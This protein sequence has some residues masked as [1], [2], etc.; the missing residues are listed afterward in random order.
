[1]TKGAVHT[2][3][4]S[5]AIDYVKR[6]HPLQL[7]LPARDADAVRRRLPAPALP[8]R[9]DE[10]RQALRGLSADRAHGHARGVA[11]LALYLVLRRSGVRHRQAY[12]IDGGAG[13]V[14]L[15]SLRAAGRERPGVLLDDGR[16][17]DASAFRADYDECF[18]AADGVRRL[19]DVA[20][21]AG[22]PRRR[23][24]GERLGPPHRRRARSSASA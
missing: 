19:R 5:I 21:A 10:M 2:M 20:D 7:H 4:M 13:L 9:E 1:M 14:K 8:G 11:A 3:T 12:P 16:R 15:D 18:F 24:P 17:V 23:S 6:W 22:R